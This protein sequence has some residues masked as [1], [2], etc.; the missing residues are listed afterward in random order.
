MGI[1]FGDANS[2]FGKKGDK[3]KSSLVLSVELPEI[4][5]K[6]KD[7]I[8]V[9]IVVKGVEGKEIVAAEISISFNKDLVEASVTNELQPKPGEIAEGWIVNAKLENGVIK[10]GPFSS[11]ELKEDG[12]F[13]LVPFIIKNVQSDQECELKFTKVSLQNFQEEVPVDEVKNGKIYI[14]TA[15]EEARVLPQK[16]EFKVIGN[17]FAGDI[18]FVY[19]LPSKGEVELKIYDISGKLV[20]TVKKAEEIGT[21]KW[22]WED[23]TRVQAG[24]YFSLLKVNGK[25]VGVKKLVL[26]Y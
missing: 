19:S 11:S 1:L 17:P 6:P 15:V 18:T 3:A 21:H 2:S 25:V 10:I 9:P 26:L 22:R 24:M 13:I 5:A 16:L 4:K 8:W 23:A 20:K 12:E 14:V 7:T